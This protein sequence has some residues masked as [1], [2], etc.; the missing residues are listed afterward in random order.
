M[1]TEWHRYNLKR[2]VAQLAPVSNEVF[3][4]KVAT[5]KEKVQY[6]DFGFPIEEP[7]QRNAKS[8]KRKANS[9][10]QDLLNRGRKNIGTKFEK[11]S[12]S[13]REVSPATSHI[14]TFSLG[15][16]K[17]NSEFEY[18]TDDL[19]SEVSVNLKD[20]TDYNTEEDFMSD[21]D[22][23][24]E[25]DEEE[26]LAPLLLTDC[27]YCGVQFDT[28]D[29]NMAHMIAHHN[30]YIPDLKYLADRE[31]L[32]R[33]L[34]DTV[35]LDKECIKCGF[36]SKKLIGIRQHIHAKGHACIP[37]ESKEQRQLFGR[38]YDFSELYSD[39]DE[40]EDNSDVT[41]NGEYTVAKIDLS[42]VQLALPNGNNLGHRSMSKYYRQNFP[43]Q[44]RRSSEGEQTLSA[45]NKE[46]ERLIRLQETVKHKKEV[47]RINLINNKITNR[48]LSNN[49]L[50]YKNN[51]ENY[52]NQ[53]F[54]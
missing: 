32:V 33:L 48:E 9:L 24:E 36:H 29:D 46:N 23:T 17:S 44:L 8:S 52:R 14:S 47:N 18:E 41:D 22:L 11:C 51:L 6:D 25:D 16:L 49:V 39:E 26:E 28:L 21:G 45:I 20:E 5:S 35:I 53:R 4:C 38:F 42:G 43:R 15:T 27:F 1:K 31:G 13:S 10:R 37:Y 30:L 40:V 34:S 50:K 3:Q 7:N 2:R 54:G 12:I 19:K